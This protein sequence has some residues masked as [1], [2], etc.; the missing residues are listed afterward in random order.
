[1]KDLITKLN[2]ELTV[3]CEPTHYSAIHENSTIDFFLSN[4][5]S[6]DPR[7]LNKVNQSD[8]K[9]VQAEFQLTS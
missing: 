5:T 1:M 8:H 7:V 4:I 6:L 9:P 2:L 3:T